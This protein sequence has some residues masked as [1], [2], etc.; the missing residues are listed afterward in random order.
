MSSKAW[1]GNSPFGDRLPTTEWRQ[2]STVARHLSD[3]VSLAAMKQKVAEVVQNR[4]N[5]LP[6]RKW[7][8]KL[9]L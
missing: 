7:E 2:P 8:V 1:Q 3:N 4:F 6:G 5:L 9:G